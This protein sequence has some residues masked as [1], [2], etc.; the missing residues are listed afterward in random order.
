MKPLKLTELQKKKIL[1]MC[2]KLYPEYEASIPKSAL[3]TEGTI[4]LGKIKGSYLNAYKICLFFHWFEF[5]AKHLAPKIQ[6]KLPLIYKVQ[7]DID[8]SENVL[9]D[10]DPIFRIYQE[11]KKLKQ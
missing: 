10:K 5:C 11:F 9:Y 8:L 3:F 7:N 6:S 1:E 4:K 2:V